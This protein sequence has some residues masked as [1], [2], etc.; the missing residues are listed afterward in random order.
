MDWST[1]VRRTIEG[2]P[3]LPYS[4]TW[5]AKHGCS[6]NVYWKGQKIMTCGRP[7]QYYCCGYL[8]EVF[9]ETLKQLPCF[10]RI[11]SSQIKALMPYAYLYTDKE[12]YM[13]KA[14][15]GKLIELGWADEIT[16]PKEVK[17]G[18]I[19]QIWWDKKADNE[20]GH[21][22]FITGYDEPY[23]WTISASSKNNPIGVVTDYYRFDKPR[24]VW[25]IARMKEDFLQS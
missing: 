6:K 17:Y 7:P 14:L 5:Q 1:Q 9:I 15:P 18:D 16:N 3:K 11:T 12:E 8:F 24:R 13:L 22:V 4:W 19:A 10:E 21:S 25:S 20:A 2:M 23:M